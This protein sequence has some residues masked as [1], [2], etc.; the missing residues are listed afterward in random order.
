MT[1]EE[2]YQLKAFARQDGALLSVLWIGSFVCYILGISTPVLGTVAL[3]LIMASP[4]Y[5]ANRLRHFR[6]GAR[7][8]VI[9]FM[10][11][12]A[13]TA[14]T[15]FYAAL[16]LAAAIYIYFAFIDNGYLLGTIHQFLGTKEGRQ[17]VELYGMTGQIQDNLKALAEL[18]PIDYAVN[19]LSINII[20]GL[21]LGVPIAAVMQRSGLRPSEK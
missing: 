15:F 18:R 14:M 16:L 7:E 8:G 17:V 10:R 5:A 11:G 13:Y 6:D 20:I 3:L 21:I 1:P 4:F 2:F 9:S 19:M 12:Y